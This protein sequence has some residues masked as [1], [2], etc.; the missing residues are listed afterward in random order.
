M[1]PLDRLAGEAHLLRKDE[2]SLFQIA[3]E[4]AL[5]HERERERTDYAPD[6]L[7]WVFWWYLATI[8]LSDR[9]LAR[10]AEAAPP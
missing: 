3:N 2:R 5:R 8:E 1:L 7:D 10:Q 4:F 9:P 6:F